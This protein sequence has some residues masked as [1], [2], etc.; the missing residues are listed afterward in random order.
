MNEFYLADYL[1]RWQSTLK[2]DLEVLKHNT[3][4]KDEHRWRVADIERNV[5]WLVD[6][7][8]DYEQ[9]ISKQNL[10]I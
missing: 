6:T 9:L 7:L 5:V 1:A 10:G 3:P 8:K 4:P 2:T